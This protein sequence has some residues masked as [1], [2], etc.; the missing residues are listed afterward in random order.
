MFFKN[1]TIT[2]NEN[3]KEEDDGGSVC[4]V[5]SLKSNISDSVVDNNE[6]FE[7]EE[8]QKNYFNKWKEQTFTGEKS[9]KQ[10]TVIDNDCDKINEN[11]EDENRK[12][13]I[14][15]ISIDSI[16]YYYEYDL[17]SARI[18]MW[19]IATE[20]MNEINDEFTFNSRYI[21]TNSQ[22]KISV[23]SPY[24]FIGLNYHHTI[25]ELEINYVIKE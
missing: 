23:I 15:V 24:S 3:E 20:I 13:K 25:S 22:N 9:P 2:E 11:D 7:M 19:N 4:V 10:Q 16:P 18:K 8:E 12:D 5:G 1:L 14:Y 6:V 21:F 17:K